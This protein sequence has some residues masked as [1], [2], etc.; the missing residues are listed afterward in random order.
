MKYSLGSIAKAITACTVAALGAATAAAGGYDLSQL[1]VMQWLSVLGAG[2]VAFAG[3]F[4][5]PNKPQPSPE[6]V[7]VPPVADVA[8]TAI[9]Q[10]VQNAT[11]AADELDRVKQATRDVLGTIPVLGPAAQAAIDSVKIPGL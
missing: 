3:V 4:A 10:T 6:P 7:P 11:Q 9:Q 2:L 8:I 5:V 1:D